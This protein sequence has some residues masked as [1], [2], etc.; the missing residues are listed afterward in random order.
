MSQTIF[1]VF[2]DQCSLI[3]KWQTGFDIYFFSLSVQVHE[4]DQRKFALAFD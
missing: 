4:E 1:N 3:V 2:L